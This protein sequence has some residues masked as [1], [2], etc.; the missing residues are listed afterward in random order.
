ML[1]MMAPNPANTSDVEVRFISETPDRAR[2]ELHRNLERHGD[3]WD[4]L[5]DELG[6]PGGWP[7]CLRRFTERMA[8]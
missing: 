6:S 3:G 5:R 1:P 8:A 7:G 4:G 2:V